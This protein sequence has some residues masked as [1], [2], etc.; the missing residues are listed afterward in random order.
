MQESFGNASESSSESFESSSQIPESDSEV[1]VLSQQLPKSHSL[2]VSTP[3]SVGVDAEEV[4]EPESSEAPSGDSSAI[5]KVSLS[6]LSKILALISS[7]DKEK[8]TQVGTLSGPHLSIY[9]SMLSKRQAVP[10]IEINNEVEHRPPRLTGPSTDLSDCSGTCEVRDKVG[11]CRLDLACLGNG[12]QLMEG[13]RSEPS[14]I[15]SSG[16]PKCYRSDMSGKCRLML[17]CLFTKR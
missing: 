1:P 4:I 6:E 14:I 16:C 11:I 2:F 5:Q 10:T 9:Q 7:L 13:V 12:G 8:L 3:S 15:K 17:T